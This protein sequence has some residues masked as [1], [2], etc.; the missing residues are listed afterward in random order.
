MT[1]SDNCFKFCAGA[2]ILSSAYALFHIW[3]RNRLCNNEFASKNDMISYG[4][5]QHSSYQIRKI[6]LN[7]KSKYSSDLQLPSFVIDI[8]EKYTKII[9]PSYHTNTYAK[10]TIFETQVSVPVGGGNIEATRH[11]FNAIVIEPN[12]CYPKGHVSMNTNLALT[13]PHTMYLSTD[14]DIM[15]F[16]SILKSAN[17]QSNAINFVNGKTFVNYNNLNQQMTLY[18]GCKVENNDILTYIWSTDRNK[19]VNEML[20]QTDYP[21]RITSYVLSGLFGLITGIMYINKN[22]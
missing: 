21:L 13:M 16:K 17:I 4:Q 5:M 11:V 6:M 2:T 15:S 8:N 10:G 19:V 7:N 12:E 14:Q 1:D 18:Q 22:Y 3:R 20:N 9:P